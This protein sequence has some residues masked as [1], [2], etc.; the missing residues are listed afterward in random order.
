MEREI[1]FR[2]CTT[3]R[4]CVLPP[5]A[6]FP[7]FVSMCVSLSLSLCVCVCVCVCGILLLTIKLC[8]DGCVCGISLSGQCMESSL[9]RLSEHPLCALLDF[10]EAHRHTQAQTHT[11]THTQT[12]T[13]THIQT[14]T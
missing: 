8:G 9:V 5:I 14:N 4:L 11:S 10:K 3:E 12:H 1:L 7:M 13:S 2:I 6:A